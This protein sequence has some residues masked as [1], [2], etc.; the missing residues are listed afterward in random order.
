MRRI[1]AVQ[2]ADEDELSGRR[3]EIEP[4]SALLEQL[5]AVARPKEAME[6]LDLEMPEAH[7]I[8]DDER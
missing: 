7:R 2:V 5:H 8:A 6:Q 4:A 3:S 1:G